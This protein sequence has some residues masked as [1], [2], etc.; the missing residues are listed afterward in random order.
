MLTHALRVDVPCSCI[1]LDD[2]GDGDMLTRM[3]CRHDFHSNCI[4]P[5]LALHRECPLCKRD[6]FA[7]HFQPDDHQESPTLD[8]DDDGD[9]PMLA[10]DTAPPVPVAPRAPRFA[11]TGSSASDS[12]NSGDN[13]SL[14]AEVTH[15]ALPRPLS[16]VVVTSAAPL[17]RAEYEGDVT[18]LVHATNTQSAPSISD[19]S[20]V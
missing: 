1:C 16:A 20:E 6:V 8:V 3:P 7:M 10:L 19:E 14:H 4:G 17:H 2:Y 18:W 13:I 5:W 11:P 9:I 15:D 12:D